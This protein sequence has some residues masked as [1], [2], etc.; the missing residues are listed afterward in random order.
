MSQ[1]MNMV[2][3]RDYSGVDGFG[4]TTVEDLNDLKKALVAGQDINPVAAAP[5]VGFPLRIESLERTLK[6]TTYRMEHIRLW[7]EVPKLPAFN[8]VEE[9][10]QIQEYGQLDQG[11]FIDEGSLPDETDATYERKFT[12][13]KFM[14][15]TR[16]VTHVMSLVKP[17]HGNVLAQE[18]ISGTMYLLRRIERNLFFARSDLDPVQWDGF[19]K[20]IE[21]GATADNIIDLRGQPLSEDVLI[22][23]ALTIQDAPNYGTPTHLYINP[24]VKADLAKTFFPKAR[25]DLFQKTD[26]GMVGLDIR[27]FTSPAGDVMF[28]PNV[29]ID[30]GGGVPAGPVGDSSKRPG[31][32]SITTAATTPPNASS[33]F[34]ATDGG[35]Y[36]YYVIAVNKFGQSAPVLADAAAITVAVGD[37]V[38]F[39]VTPDPGQPLPTYYKVLRSPKDDTAASSRLILRVANDAGAGEK[40]IID[41]NEYLPGTTRGFMFQLNMENMSFKQLAPMI[42]VPLATVDTSIRWMQLIY[43]APVLY[44]PRRNV[45][46]RNIGRSPGYVGAP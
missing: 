33:L 16:R 17:A 34:G 35:D 20:L 46:F 3:W 18:V 44:T 43:G 32:P 45:I 24:K 39:G 15:T 13:I 40:T 1:G 38:R 37:D 25:Y 6:N 10:N 26:S 30:D 7:R 8:T 29:F 12:I 41:I 9:F 4:Q 27:G 31:T 2:S 14:G 21:D 23:A 22:D 28:E 42:K 11:A 36:W 5:G 19:E